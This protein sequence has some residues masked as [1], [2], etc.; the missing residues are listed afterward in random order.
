[1]LNLNERTETKPKPT[2]I[3]VCAHHSA[4]LSYKN[5]TEYF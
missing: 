3:D 2:L 4:Q 5:S 1:M